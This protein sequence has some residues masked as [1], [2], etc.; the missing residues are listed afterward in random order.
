MA[1]V[2]SLAPF[3]YVSSN[4]STDVKLMEQMREQDIT[5]RKTDSSLPRFSI[6]V[7]PSPFSM[8]RGW[9]FFL[10]SPYEGVTYI[11]TVMH[12]AGFPTRIIDVRYELDPVRAAYD[13]L[14]AQWW[15]HD[16]FR[17]MAE[18][19]AGS[20]MARVSDVRPSIWN[21]RRAPSEPTS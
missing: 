20:I 11:A 16:L 2:P 13:Q 19:L 3:L 17:R 14:R 4:S 21:D 7:G 8:P 5:P 12:N 18:H 10:T 15:G 6:V 1:K 9:E